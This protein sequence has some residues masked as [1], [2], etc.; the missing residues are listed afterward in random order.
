MTTLTTQNIF[1]VSDFKTTIDQVYDLQVENKI[2]TRKL[3]VNQR[4]EYLRNL[5]NVILRH[6]SEIEKALFMD[7]RKSKVE[8]DSTEIFPVL[9]EIRLF[10]KKHG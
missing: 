3:T 5:E 2:N 9:A 7:L 10:R 6:R 8:A 4:K 1:E